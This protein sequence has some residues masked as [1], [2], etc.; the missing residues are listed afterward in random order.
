MRLSDIR[1]EV[2]GL[3]ELPPHSLLIHEG[4]LYMSIYH[5]ERNQLLNIQSLK[6]GLAMQM[7][8]AGPDSLFEKIVSVRIHQ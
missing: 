4:E 3:A 8:T 7:V 1:T 5:D 6:P 2:V